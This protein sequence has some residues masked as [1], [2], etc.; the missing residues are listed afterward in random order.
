MKIGII[1]YGN[2]GKAF[3]KGLVSTGF[4]QND[5]VINAKTK[6]T[7]DSIGNDFNDV[8]VTANKEEL[9][10]KSDVIIL[11]IEPMNAKEVLNEIKAYNIN[12]K[13]IISFMAGITMAEIRNELGEKQNAVKLIRVMPNIAIQEGNGVLGITYNDSDYE[14]IQDVLNV[15]RRLGYVLKLDETS[16]NYITVTAASGLAFAAC[17]MDSYQAACNTLLNNNNISKEI[18]IRIF[19]NVVDMVKN[20]DCSLNDIVCRITTKG[21]TTEAGMNILDAKLVTENLVACMH[22][23]FERA[24]NII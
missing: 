8:Y 3:V 11:I 2:L 14:I 1:G 19:E 4:N 5:I 7:R 23:S 15:L 12:Q 24:N 20:E 13:I 18:T 21:G 6:K 10:N 22:K 9:V 16:L 17:I